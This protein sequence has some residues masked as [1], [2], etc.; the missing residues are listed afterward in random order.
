MAKRKN[1]LVRVQAFNDSTTGVR[2]S[3]AWE[4]GDDGVDRPVMSVWNR[5]RSVKTTF[6]FTTTGWLYTGTT[7]EKV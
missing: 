1:W 2:L 3:F 4:K 7:V 5:E 6:R